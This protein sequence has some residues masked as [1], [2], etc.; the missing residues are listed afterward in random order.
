MTI[1]VL[2]SRLS[3]GRGGL[4]T[5]R[6]I[7]H[8]FNLHT[9]IVLPK[10]RN[11]NA[12]PDWLMVWHPLLEIPGHCRNGFV[13]QGD[14]IRVNPKDLRP[15]LSTSIFKVML[16]GFESL[17]DLGVDLGGD[18]IHFALRIPSS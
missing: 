1:D 2:S 10:S 11:S 7:C 6:V 4:R 16:H 14:M 5:I 18:V 15:S 13:I 8:Y 9:H 17:V 3:L 12:G